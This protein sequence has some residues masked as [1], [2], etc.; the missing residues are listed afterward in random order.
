MAVIG[1]L[2]G[3]I[4]LVMHVCGLCCDGRGTS[5]DKSWCKVAIEL[6]FFLIAGKSLFGAW[7]VYCAVCTTTIDAGS[8]VPRILESLEQVV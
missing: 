2:G 6:L 3:V 7:N 1:V 4:A 5:D 8:A